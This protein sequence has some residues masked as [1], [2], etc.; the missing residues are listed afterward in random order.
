MEF[1]RKRRKGHIEDH[2][3][4]EKI[5]KRFTSSTKDDQKLKVTTFLNAEIQSQQTKQWPLLKF[6]RNYFDDNNKNKEREILTKYGVKIVQKSHTLF[7]F[8]NEE[9]D[10]EIQCQTLTCFS[11]R[12]EYVW[13]TSVGNLECRGHYY[14]P[15]IFSS[16]Y[17]CCKS[18]YISE[19]QAR[20]VSCGEL[21]YCTNR[22]HS[23]SPTNAR[24]VENIP[25]WLILVVFGH[26]NQSPQRIINQALDCH[27]VSFPPGK[28][29]S[30]SKSSSSLIDDD[31][32]GGDEGFL[33]SNSLNLWRDKFHIC[34][35]E[36]Y[37]KLPY[38]RTSIW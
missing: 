22:D 25:L 4:S 6:I 19:R 7:Q 26:F 34:L 5:L 32:V 13:G 36:S 3:N 29:S 18:P 38:I 16:V 28:H 24:D 27:L 23:I 33:D 30:N 8:D 2:F 1:T 31:S 17:P 12:N 9:E 10:L 14:I 15:S 20:L 37:I 35:L 11:C 21:P